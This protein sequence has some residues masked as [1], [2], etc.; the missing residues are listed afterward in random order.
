MVYFTYSLS[1]DMSD[2][3]YC[4]ETGADFFSEI[5]D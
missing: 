4:S 2:I 1:P 5:R 3:I